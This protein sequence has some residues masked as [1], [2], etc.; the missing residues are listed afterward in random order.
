MPQDGNANVLDHA[1]RHWERSFRAAARSDKC[2]LLLDHM[3]KLGFLPEPELMLEGTISVVEAVCSYAGIDGQPL[4]DFLG[5]QKYD[6]SQA[7]NARYAFTFDLCGK[8]YARVLVNGKLETIDLADLL[9]H[10]WDNYEVAGYDRIWISHPD[11][12]ALT[13]EEI[14]E[15]EEQVADDLLFDYSEGVVQPGT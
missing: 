10:P 4:D 11:W 13:D 6:L 14:R 3:G 15:L 1:F 9:G 8:S 12:S 7:T 5:M 2:A